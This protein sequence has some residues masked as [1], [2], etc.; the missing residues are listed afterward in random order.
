MADHPSSWN[1][2]QTCCAG[3]RIYVQSGIYEEFLKRFTEEAQKL[4]LGDPFVADTY[5][6]PQISKVHFDVRFS[7]FNISML[8]IPT[9]ERDAAHH[10]LHRVGKGARRQAALRRRATRHGGLLDTA[11]HFHRDA[12][13]DAH[14]EGGDLWPR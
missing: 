3:S 10:G 9:N 4:K 8:V 2:G 11:D 13:G 14:R 7:S 12:H 6:G 1:H 5:Q